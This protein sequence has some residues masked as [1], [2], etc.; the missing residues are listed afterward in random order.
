MS[1]T[2]S[3]TS[4]KTKSTTR[5][6]TTSTISRVWKTSFQN[7]LSTLAQSSNFV[8]AVEASI[9]FVI[10]DDPSQSLDYY[11]NLADEEMYNIKKTKHTAR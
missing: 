11:I 8:F 3:V 2:A 1:S 6:N 7:A 9:G 5:E 10:A 4:A